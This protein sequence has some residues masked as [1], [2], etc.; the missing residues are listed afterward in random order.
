MNYRTIVIA[1]LA[2]ATLG[3][4]AAESVVTAASAA[5]QAALVQQ[6]TNAARPLNM[7]AKVLFLDEASTLPSRGAN[8]TIMVSGRRLLEAIGYRVDWDASAGS[9]AAGRPGKPALL[10]Q[11]GRRE[12]KFG[13]KTVQLPAAPYLGEG[14][15]WVPLRS[16]AEAAGLTVT[17]DAANGYAHVKDPKAL[18]RI[19]LTTRADNR[20]IERPANLI[21]YFKS[22]MGLDVN[23]NL[24]PPDYYRE[25]TNVMIAAGEP[26]DLILLQN[27]YQYSDELLSSFALD[28][29]EE[30]N[31]FPRLKALAA[32]AAGGRTI[33]DRSYGIARP[34]D[35]H[36][37]PFPAIRQDWLDKLGLA[38]P[39]TMEEVYAVL[40]QFT[41]LD[42]DGNG[43]NDTYGM[44]GYATAAGL[45]SFAWVEQA[46]TGSP[47]RFAVLNGR[48][49]DHALGAGET[50]ALRWLARAYREGLIDKEFAVLGPEQ[51]AE[52]I[53]GSRAGLAALSLRDAA[54]L[55]GGKEEWIPLSG[56]K[57]D[58]LRAPIA[59]WNT[60]ATDTYIVTRLSR[61]APKTI[62]QWLDSGLAMN[63]TGA[64]DGIEGFGPADRAAVRSLFGEPD[65]LRSEALKSVPERA[66]GAY[67]TAVKEWQQTS[68]ADVVVPAF[69]GLWSTGKYAELNAELKDMQIK[70]ILGELSIEEWEQYTKTLAASEAYQAMMAELAAIQGDGA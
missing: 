1:A 61:V 64:W 31:A 39:R 42:P 15:L 14:V 56:L 27:H 44:T 30:L 50:E 35:P 53:R 49:V 9:L 4:L 12:A 57:A 18:P 6:E 10:L 41:D 32:E 36:D 23:P 66:R 34:R 37:A 13:D 70:V 67:E 65:L 60:E 62:L 51:A 68:D 24:V 59:P 48:V 45:G 58:S 29:T 33:N 5:P 21:A 25:K 63:E 2:S 7:A 20:V 22:Q 19:T 17:W 69:S 47:A 40:R 54:A 55:T 28:L 3:G 26:G 43:K 8:G 11:A 52:R 16:V 38:Q 46:F